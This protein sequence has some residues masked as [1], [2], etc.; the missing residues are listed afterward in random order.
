VLATNDVTACATEL[1]DLST[2]TLNALP[3][4]AISYGTLNTPPS[5]T[6]QV[7]IST[8][9]IEAWS[10]YSTDID[11]D[12]H[13]DVLYASNDGKIAWYK[14]T[15]GAGTFGAEQTISTNVIVPFSVY[16]MDLDGDGD[17]DVLSASINDNKIA[18]YENTD[19]AG[20][21]GAQNVISTDANKATSVY[22]TDLDGDGD[23]DVLSSSFS[24]NKIAWYENDGTGNFGSQ[25]VI[26]TAASG[27]SSVYA[28]DMDGDGDMDVL[29]A[30]WTD[31]KIAWY[32]NTDGAGTFGAQNVISTVAMNASSVYA[33]DMDGD[34]DMDVVSAS[35]RDDKIAWYENT[36]GDGTFGAQQV[37]S[38]AA[39]S[40]R[41][42]YATDLDGDGDMDV[43]SAS[44]ADN[45]IAWYENTDGDGTFGA[46]Q[47]ISTAALGAISV[48][49]TDI[50][51]DGDMDVLSASFTD[52]KI[53]WYKNDL[54]MP[55]V[56]V[57]FN[58]TKRVAMPP[59]GPG[60]QRM[61][62]LALIPIIQ[63]KIHWFPIL[64]M[65]IL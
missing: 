19:G 60:H 48:Y 9:A 7:A 44:Y 28:T 38:T 49:A 24:D 20:T 52:D 29:S 12:G 15:D 22:S 3:D 39:L 16:A 40:T 37:I 64:R 45:K 56:T 25:I 61:V 33:T 32:E 50:D 51:G 13:M 62:L 23:M 5:F 1:S 42:V 21:F 14:N 46:Q 4:V 35:N 10:V 58:L 53:A 2:V 55:N 59:L 54:L 43:L 6:E 34:G 65:A 17:M 31:N 8:S 41:S 30:S 27:A 57:I 47:V 26:S 63:T 18:W 11:G 36:D